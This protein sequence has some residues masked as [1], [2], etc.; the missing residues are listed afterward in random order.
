MT[1]FAFTSESVTEGHPDQMADHISDSILHAMLAPDPMS[2]A[3]C[4][5]MCTT[6]SAFVAGAITPQPSVDP[7]GT[8]PDNGS[9]RE[10][11]GTP[12]LHSRQSARVHCPLL[13][14]A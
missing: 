6:T 13:S 14:H 9:K 3:A 1:R 12:R 11:T 5:P 8:G 10:G 2:Q 7:D 4:D